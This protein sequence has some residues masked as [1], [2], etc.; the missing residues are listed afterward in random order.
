MSLIA[1]ISSELIFFL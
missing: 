1:L